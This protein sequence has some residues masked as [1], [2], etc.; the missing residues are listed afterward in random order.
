MAAFHDPPRRDMRMRCRHAN[1]PQDSFG[2]WVNDVT[3][4]TQA[5]QDQAQAIGDTAQLPE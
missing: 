5:P 2:E 4:V 3:A 1:D